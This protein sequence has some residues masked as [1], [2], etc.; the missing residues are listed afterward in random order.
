MI[1]YPN[2]IFVCLSLFMAITLLS[3]SSPVKSFSLDLVIV[4]FRLPRALVFCVALLSLHWVKTSVGAKL[5]GNR[6]SSYDNR[7]SSVFLK[8]GCMTQMPL[9]NPETAVIVISS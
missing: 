9:F 4:S 6:W 2:G 5:S 7:Q 1:F 8:Y 3:H